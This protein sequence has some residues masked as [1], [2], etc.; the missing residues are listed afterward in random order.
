MLPTKILRIVSTIC[1]VMLSSVAA[2]NAED[3]IARQLRGMLAAPLG[4]DF[5]SKSRNTIVQMFMRPWNEIKNECNDGY[6]DNYG[7]IQVSP[8]QE[9]PLVSDDHLGGKYTWWLHYQPV[10]YSLNSALGTRIEFEEMAAACNERGVGIIVDAVINHMTSASTSGVGSAGNEWNGPDQAYAYFSKDDFNVPCSI[11]DWQD[12]DMV[13]N[14]QMGDLNDLK[15]DSSYVQQQI[16]NF[17][18][19]LIGIPGV[20]GFRVDAAKLI[21]ADDM[22]AILDQVSGDPFVLLEILNEQ[23]AS[24]FGNYESLGFGTDSFCRNSIEWALGPKNG[25]PWQFLNGIENNWCFGSGNPQSGNA[26]KAL[27]FVSNHD[28]ETHKD[29]GQLNY[30]NDNWMGTSSTTMYEAALAWILMYPHGVPRLTS[31]YGD[32]TGDW[33]DF[34]NGANAP[35]NSINGFNHGNRD[36]TWNNMHRSTSVQ[37]LLKIHNA[38]SNPGDIK[39][40]HKERGENHEQVS[41][42]LTSISSGLGDV[43]VAINA[44]RNEYDVSWSATRSTSLPDGDYC[45]AY[46]EGDTMGDSCE[47]ETYEVRG[48]MVN[49]MGAAKELSQTGNRILILSR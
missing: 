13:Q 34:G 40:T 28:S 9:H 11:T 33:P 36:I 3:S 31:G 49:F 32:Q 25:N 48:G 12:T 41:W 42:S 4:N 6:M 14:C 7:A 15:T 47:K 8:P 27:W 23:L 43:F 22:K 46:L 1:I 17:L 20:I 29:W 37:N 26:L 35:P 2:T 30:Y 18:N 45:N 10:S 5:T 39:V 16:V 21:P 38:A 44:G 24:Q 19:D